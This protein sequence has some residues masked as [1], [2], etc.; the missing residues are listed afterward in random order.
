MEKYLEDS[1]YINR[2]GTSDEFV[3][4]LGHCSLVC[5]YLILKNSC[6][7]INEYCDVFLN[8]TTIC[9]S[10]YEDNNLE[11]IRLNENEFIRN[12][13]DFKLSEKETN[14]FEEL[15][16]LLD[17]GQRVFVQTVSQRLPFSRHYN[18]DFDMA[19]FIPGHG[20]LIVHQDEKF[21]YFVESPDLVNRLYLKTY[22]GNS[23]IG[24][25]EKELAKKVF[26]DFCNIY[27]IDIDQNNLNASHSNFTC[28][29][30]QSIINY[31]KKSDYNG[32]SRIF[33]GREAI[34][35]LIDICEEQSISLNQI[36]IH[37]RDYYDFFDWKIWTIK[38]ARKALCLCLNKKYDYI[39][40][41]DIS[42]SIIEDAFK[43][44]ID[45][46]EKTFRVMGKKYFKGDFLLDSAFK[47]NFVDILES[48]DEIIELLK[49]IV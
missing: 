30:Q 37:K 17:R 34:L 3:Y 22:K 39:K 1:Y 4:S 7:N 23:E 33:Y 36:A 45:I 20:L 48:E 16:S 44:N 24:L 46:W 26:G 38:G 31:T 29:I 49:Q 28:T 40:N 43:K 42:I 18:S 2:E 11:T 41:K 35:R 21:F 25:L 47:K 32:G 10:Q 15:E 27:T 14:A 8:D 6:E 9:L 19:D 5:A 13:F 12:V